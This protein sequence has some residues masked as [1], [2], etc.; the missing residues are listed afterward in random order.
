MKVSLPA[1]Q[2]GEGTRLD[3]WRISFF[4]E[5]IERLQALPEVE[6]AGVINITP[7]TGLH[8]S[9]D[10]SIEGRPE[11]PAGQKDEARFYVTDQNFFRAMQIPLKRG[12]LF[13]PQETI[14]PR[15][16]V[17]INETFARKYFPNEDPI[18]Q[19]I[20]LDTRPTY[21]P[22]QIIG[23]VGDVKHLK[24]D[25]EAEPVAYLPIPESPP[26]AMTFILRAKGDAL[27]LASGARNM[28]RSRYTQLPVGDLRPLESLLADSIARQRFNTFL[29]AAFAGVALLLA[30][31]G[32]YGVMS[33][34]VAQ[35]TQEIGIRMAIGAQTGDVRNLIVK[36][37]MKLT[38]LGV[39]IGLLAAAGLARLIKN[40]LFGIEATDPTTFVVVTFL[41]ISVALLACFIPARRAMKVDPMMALRQQ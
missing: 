11:N 7:F 6:S 34:A 22:T 31:I 21:V 14:E 9:T 10:F 1:R 38:I 2:I 5:A 41:L 8:L 23:V 29:L 17:V 4:N 16:V 3:S 32:I 12:R 19:R 28:I 15:H 36:Q 20:T 18:G 30:A 37:G 24:L 13:T 26:T 25:D 40:L 33:Y 27:T 35:R 39:A